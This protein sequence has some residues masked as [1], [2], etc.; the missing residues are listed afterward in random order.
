MD[1]YTAFANSSFGRSLLSSL[2]MPTPTALERHNPEQRTLIAG[3]VL[4]G[5]TG[6]G[7]VARA[8]AATLRAGGCDVQV[9]AQNGAQNGDQA[10]RIL[11]D[12]KTW[13]GTPESEQKFKGLVFD[14][15]GIR[16]TG[17]LKALWSFF[18]PVVKKMTVCSRIVVIGR[19]P[20]QCSDPTMAT[21]QRALEGLVRSLGKEI[22]KGGSSQLLY[23]A[24][25][26]EDNLES[27]LRFFLSPKSAYVSGQVVRIGAANAAKHV[28]N[29]DWA[30]PL[31]GKVALVTGAARGIG[32]AIAGVLARDGAHVICLDIPAAEAELKVVAERIGGSTLALDI[33]DPAA[34]QTIAA[35]V[36][37][38]HDGLDVIVHNAGITRDK[39]LGN[40]PNKFWDMVIDIN[41]SSAERI[42]DVLLADNA[43]KANGRIICVSS[44]SGIA[45]NLGQTNYA[46]S[47]AGVIGMVQAM[48]PVLKAKNITINAV[49]PGFIE[50]QMTAAI[51]F[52]I[53]EAGRRLNSMSQGG[54]PVDVA[55]TI[56]WFASPASGGVTGQVVRVCGQSLLGA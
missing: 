3:T 4:F 45:G 44:I 19:P 7:A 55:E 12:A 42:N 23:V 38:M 46:V 34:P 30:K 13:D 10:G 35:F 54:L 2:G 33:T 25:G 37:K 32:E 28:V 22:K 40:M 31:A 47:K 11:V 20:E 6:D 29:I 16:N 26:A 51:P 41:L 48:A 14:A 18:H 50:T 43:F 36:K 9:Y 1:R 53:R 17:E 56:A 8:I 5:T 21:A 39:M 15:S 27:S 24:E 52:S 49:A